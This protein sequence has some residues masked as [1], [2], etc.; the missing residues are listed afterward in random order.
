MRSFRSFT[1]ITA[2]FPAEMAA[3]LSGGSTVSLSTGLGQAI[4][5]GSI[6]RSCQSSWRD[7]RC[8]F[9]WSRTFFD[10]TRLTSMR[11]SEKPW[12]TV[13]SMPTTPLRAESGFSGDLGGYEFLNPGTLLLPI[14]Q[15][16]TGRYEREQK[17]D[18]ATHVSHGWNWREGRGWGFSG[19]PSGMA[20]S[21]HWCAPLLEDDM[22][23]YDELETSLDHGEPL[24]R[25]DHPGIWS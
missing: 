9:I 25:G 23:Q 1:W 12:S 17:P 11:P 7:S 15:V 14:E 22:G 13:S 2:S 20:R 16:R 19:H 3:R 21:R 5:L 10:A 4:S 24:S 18:S 8:P 6:S